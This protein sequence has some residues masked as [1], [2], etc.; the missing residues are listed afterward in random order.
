MLVAG[1]D[2]LISQVR[3][4][5]PQGACPPEFTF[6]GASQF[7]THDNELVELE[8]CSRTRKGGRRGR[9]G[10]YAGVIDFDWLVPELD[11]TVFHRPTLPP[12]ALQ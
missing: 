7:R 2:R 3:V 12:R 9:P 5:K 8:S 4:V 6:R 11:V 1:H 10:N